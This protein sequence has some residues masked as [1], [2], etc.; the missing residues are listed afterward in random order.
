MEWKI[1]K[2]S[3]TLL[4]ILVVITFTSASPL[5]EA[6]VPSNI[7]TSEINYRLPTNVIPSHYTI[8]LD[9]LIEDDD[10]KTFTGEVQITVKVTE[11]TENII[12][13]YNDLSITEIKVTSVNDD[14]EFFANYD[15]DSVTHF[16]TIKIYSEG[17]E[18]R[19]FKE[20]EEYIITI[21]YSGHHRS[22]MYG[23]YR[24]SYKDEDGNTV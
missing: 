11:E 3:T 10:P 19:M 12:L 2:I 16:C 7:R 22:D 15:Y 14:T 4:Q 21:N 8:T 9:P 1:V 5:L 13:H 20:N 18:N 24:S 17:D 23:F 6:A